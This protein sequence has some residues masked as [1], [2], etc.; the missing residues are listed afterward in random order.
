MRYAKYLA[1][2]TVQLFWPAVVTAQ[3]STFDAPGLRTYVQQVLENNASLQARRSTLSAAR[4]RIG[5]AGALPDPTVSLGVMS[6]PVPS[7]DFRAEAMTQIGIGFA[8]TFPARGKRSAATSVARADSTVAASRV[9]DRE[10]QLGAAA[11]GAYFRLAFAQTAVELWRG[12]AGLADQAVVVT[13]ARYQSGAAPQTDALRARLRRARLSE[14]LRD[15]EAEVIG[16]R[17]TARALL[18]GGGE[19]P[20][21]LLLIG[22][23]GTPV[24]VAFDVPVIDESEPTLRNPS[25]QV[26]AATVQR[27]ARRA[28]L[29]EIAGR[30]DFMTSVHTGI[31]LGGRE[32]FFTASIGIPLALWSGRKQTPLAEAASM[33]LTAAEEE[34]V[35]LSLLVIAEVRT[36]LAD[37]EASRLRARQI[38]TESVPLAT[39]AAASALQQYRV[40][41]VDFTSVLETQDELFRVQLDLAQVV[42]RFGTQRAELAALTGEEWY[43]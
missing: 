5:P 38:A 28:T 14:E 18:G 25:L 9:E 35:D 30:P 4:D 1:A 6:L 16:A 32:P 13:D 26:A 17:E 27:A 12:R 8:Q 23:A 2:A 31:R 43:R 15:L 10:A 24:P 37:L 3:H 36:R 42:S 7:F 41:T 34:Y 40:G 19:V 11:T 33:D 21:G 22:V 29:L 20:D 39:A